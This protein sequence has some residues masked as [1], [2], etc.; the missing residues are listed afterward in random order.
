MEQLLS[1]AFDNLE[2]EIKVGNRAR[3]PDADKTIQ[4]YNT[5]QYNK[6]EDNAKTNASHFEFCGWGGVSPESFVRRIQ[7]LHIRYEDACSH[8]DLPFSVGLTLGRFCISTDHAGQKEA[9][10]AS[11]KSREKGGWGGEAERPRRVPHARPD[12]PPSIHDPS[13]HDPVP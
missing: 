9:A 8:P 12:Q 1:K 5:K 7:G 6:R 13:I 2:L 10:Q 3:P 4:L 11:Q